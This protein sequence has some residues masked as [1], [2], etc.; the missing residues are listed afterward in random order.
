MSDLKEFKLP[1]VGEG[2][3]EADIVRWHVKPGDQITVN[4]IIVEIETAK[5]VVE[6]PSPYEGVVAN[7]LVPEGQTADVGTPIISVNVG[8]D[9]RSAPAASRPRRSAQRAISETEDLVPAPPV[10]GAIE[11][12]HARQP[13]PEGRAA[14]GA[15]R[16]RREA[17][18]DQPAGPQGEADGTGTSR[19]D[20]QA[21]ALRDR[22]DSCG[23]GSAPVTAETPAA[24]AANGGPG[25]VPTAL[26]KPPVR[27]MARDLGVDLGEL[28]GTGPSGSI[29][30][31]DVQRAAAGTESGPVPFSSVVVP[32][33]GDSGPRA[34]G[35][36]PD[37]GRAQAHRGGG[38]GE[39]LHGPARHRVPPDRR[40]R[41]DD[42]DGPAARAARVRRG[43]G[44]AA[45][46]G[47]AG[48]DRGGRSAPDDQRELGRGRAG[49]R[50]QA[51]REPG[52]RRGD[53]PRAR[54]AR[55]SR[56]RTR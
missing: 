48:A 1:D 17:R 13:G 8:A 32:A 56:T 55:T 4:Q 6:L 3:T 47:R 49:D 50:G 43:Q 18:H 11:P 51:L 38:G 24:S 26:A 23:S 44:V 12:G 2:L 33:A 15:R 20:G 14:G 27:R 9:A 46:A 45:A 10:E 42:G 5:A 16:L 35:A 34:R 54:R 21:T 7:L 19:A 30:R 25:R 52:H 31:D 28:T 53:R 39:R 22:R 40:H 36:D 29:T 37:P 41:D